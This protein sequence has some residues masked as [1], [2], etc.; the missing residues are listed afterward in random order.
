M[1]HYF[2]N[3]DLEHN[4]KIIKV[5]IKNEDFSFIT[6]NGVFSKKG[7]DFGT[8]TLLENLDYK[9]INGKILDF[10]CGYGSIGIIVSKFTGLEVDM[11]DINKRSIE[12][13]K[14]NSKLN[15]VKTNIFESNIYENV[16]DKYDYIISNPPIRVGN[17]ILYKILFEAKDHLNDNGKLIIV[18]NKDQGAKSLMEKLKKFYNVN[19][20]AKNKGF[21]VILCS[22]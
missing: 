3:E 6:D 13:A 1:G 8:R 17:E 20:I 10:G 9:N 2:I 15:K 14:E 11:L 12:L 21:F 19:L 18:V 5:I 4:K 22:K 16:Q 7:L